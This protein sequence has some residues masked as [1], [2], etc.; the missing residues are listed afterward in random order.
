L[1]INAIPNVKKKLGKYV[2][3]FLEYVF[4]N[5]QKRRCATEI[6][7][8]LPLPRSSGRQAEL[9]ELFAPKYPP[10]YWYA[11]RKLKSMGLIKLDTARIKDSSG[12]TKYI[13][14]YVFNADF[15]IW[16]EKTADGFE[17]LRTGKELEEEEE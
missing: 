14:A 3:T 1:S 5:P 8:S 7:K 9:I 6:L 15:V 17:N 11:L 10:H 4:E 16:L 2:V 12:K 13:R